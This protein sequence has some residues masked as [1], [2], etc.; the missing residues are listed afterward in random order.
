MGTPRKAGVL[1]MRRNLSAVDATAAR[2]MGINPHK[3]KTSLKQM[4]GW[5]PIWGTLH[6]ADW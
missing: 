2:V 5:G 4:T 3:I 6:S 1:V